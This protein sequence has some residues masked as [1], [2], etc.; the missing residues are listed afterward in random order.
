V[1]RE[2][3]HHTIPFGISLAAVGN[4]I[5]KILASRQFLHSG[6]MRRFLRFVL[7]EAIRNPDIELKEYHIAIAV[8]DKPDSF[9]PRT[10]SIVRVE[11]RRL[12]SKLKEYSD[13]D[14]RTE[15]VEI[16]LSPRGYAVII[17]ERLPETPPVVTGQLRAAPCHAIAV[18]PFLSLSSGKGAK[19]FAQGL[20]EELIH[21]MAQLRNLKLLAW[22]SRFGGSAQ[23]VRETAA[24]LKVD[25][26]L[27]G[28]VRIVAGTMR[29]SAQLVNVIDGA[30]L[31]AQIYERK[32]QDVFADQD[33]LCTSIVQ[34]IGLR[35]DTAP[36]R[37]TAPGIGPSPMQQSFG[38]AGGSTKA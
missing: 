18:Q 29:I 16:A 1:A 5:E 26:I 17:R 23:K 27:E 30:L 2:Q 4:Q 19:D 11:A 31:W 24:Q 37:H 12:R 34:S 25:A 32:A 8:F 9:D 13:E 3:I 20:S 35:L 36:G 7:E 14:G 10:D 33:D 28:S 22:S 15:S 6:R 21:A 38:A